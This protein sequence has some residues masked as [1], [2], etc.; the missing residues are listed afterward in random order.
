MYAKT[1]FLAVSLF[2]LAGMSF[3][4]SAIDEVYT[5]FFSN[6]AIRGY[7]A[8]AYFTQG[9]PVKGSNEYSFEYKGATWKFSTAEHL[10]LFKSDPETYA[11]QYGG[12]CAYAI[13]NGDTASAEPDLWTI[14]NGKL[15]LNYNRRI[16]RLWRENMEEYIKQAD[17]NW[18]EFEK[19]F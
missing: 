19:E 4:A 15:Y 9:M 16:N 3:N 5:G 14:H 11:P 2:L 1:G 12:Y 17:S 18:P 6:E 7:D 8:V 13:A 10:N